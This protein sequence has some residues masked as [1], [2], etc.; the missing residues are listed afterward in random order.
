MS[1]QAAGPFRVTLDNCQGTE[2][3][4]M[5]TN[6]GS[7]TATVQ[8]AANFVQGSTVEDGNTSGFSDPLRPGQSERLTIQNVVQYAAGTYGPGSP[9]AKCQLTSYAVM[10]GSALT[11]TWTLPA[12]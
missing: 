9:G 2:A 3:D 12:Q 8:V 5:V 7:A 1:K 11:G 4:V 10:A 6:H